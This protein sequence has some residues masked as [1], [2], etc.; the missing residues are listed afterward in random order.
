M[1]VYMYFCTL[2]LGHYFQSGREGRGS[3]SCTSWK[4]NGA[5]PLSD[6]VEEVP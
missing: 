2:P 3:D 6:A 4:C 1:V 5:L